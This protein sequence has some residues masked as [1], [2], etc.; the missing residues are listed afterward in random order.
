LTGFAELHYKSVKYKIYVYIPRRAIS[1]S[2][3][4]EEGAL[5]LLPPNPH[6]PLAGAYAGIVGYMRPLTFVENYK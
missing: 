6:H 5:P 2:I 4:V 1:K 3:S